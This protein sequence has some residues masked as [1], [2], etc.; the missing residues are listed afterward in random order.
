MSLTSRIFNLF[1]PDQLTPTDGREAIGLVEGENYGG[2]RDDISLQAG[3]RKQKLEMEEEEDEGRP[4]YLHVRPTPT[5]QRTSHDA[6][7]D[8]FVTDCEIVHAGGRHWRNH[9]RSSDA[10]T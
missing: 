4:P 8:Q 9:G 2:M 6:F 7:P 10:F 3:K 5:C 1:A